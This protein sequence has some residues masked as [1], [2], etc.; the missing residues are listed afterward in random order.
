[1][2]PRPTVGCASLPLDAQEAGFYPGCILYISLWFPERHT[3]QASAAFT[4]AAVG[5][6]LVG[7][8]GSGLLSKPTYRLQQSHRTLTPDQTPDHRNAHRAPICT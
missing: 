2:A 4:T 3:G 1:M 6:V 7:N 8:I 5:G